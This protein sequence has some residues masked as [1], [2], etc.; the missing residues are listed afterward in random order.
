MT[1]LAVN[2]WEEIPR[3]RE[4]WKAPILGPLLA[5]TLMQG[6]APFERAEV[7][8][9]TR[10]PHALKDQNY[11]LEDQ[12]TF[13]TGLLGE[14]EHQYT[15]AMGD[16]Q[17]IAKGAVL[18]PT[19]PT[20]LVSI[21]ARL[22]AISGIHLVNSYCADFFR[23]GGDNQKWL[24]VAKDV[25]GAVGTLA[26]GALALANPQ[27]STPAAIVAL[28]TGAAYNAADVYTRNFLFGTDNIESVR[29]LTFNALAFH[30]DAVLPQ[31]DPSVWSLGAAA[32]VINDHQEICMPASIRAL[33]LEAIKGGRITA[34]NPS[35]GT[36]TDA[37]V[38]TAQAAN[39][40]VPAA[41]EAASLAAPDIAE[42]ADPAAQAAAGASA[43][44]ATAAANTPGASNASISK[45]ASIAAT[46]AARSTAT[47]IA[48]KASSSSID[49][50]VAK[51]SG[52]VAPAAATAAANPTSTGGAASNPSRHVTLRAGG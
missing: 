21:R 34:S 8:L 16:D 28:R 41:T 26:T 7:A 25:T 22:L 2:F 5:I 49:R 42:A 33:A 19:V 31:L 40:S 32:E 12:T 36:I 14:F 39:A 27:N 4:L 44:A 15:V 10:G 13:H 24:S 6:C 51:V 48:P 37:A 23:N 9:D 18:P 1:C 50:L 29:T 38:A 47:R 46:K 30:R 20:D 45:A 35:T 11:A 3:M 43:Q 17:M 52:V